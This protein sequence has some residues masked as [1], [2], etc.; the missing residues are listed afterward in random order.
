M[1][2]LSSVHE[3]RSRRCSPGSLSATHRRLVTACTAL[4]RDSTRLNNEKPNRVKLL[5]DF[6]ATQTWP[7]YYAQTVRQSRNILMSQK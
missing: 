1:T 6:F 2:C 5:R 7:T 3:D 4:L